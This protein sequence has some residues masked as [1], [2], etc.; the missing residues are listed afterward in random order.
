MGAPPSAASRSVSSGKP[1]PP[2]DRVS[3]P[4]PCLA[5]GSAP[6]NVPA[7]SPRTRTRSRDAWAAPAAS[8]IQPM[9]LHPVTMARR[10]WRSR[11][12]SEGLA[13]ARSPRASLATGSVPPRP[14]QPDNH[15]PEHGGE[16]MLAAATSHTGNRRWPGQNPVQRVQAA[17]ECGVVGQAR[18]QA[19]QQGRLHHQHPDRT[20]ASTPGRAITART[21]ID[22]RD[23]GQGEAEA[24]IVERGALPAPVSRCQLHAGGAK[25]R[26]GWKRRR[27]HRQRVMMVSSSAVDRVSGIQTANH[28][29]THRLRVL[30][31]GSV[32]RTRWTGDAWCRC[33]LATLGRC[34][35]PCQIMSAARAGCGKPPGRVAAG[36]HGRFRR[37]FSAW[38]PCGPPMHYM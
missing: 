22:D 10:A 36:R 13:G 18:Q 28:G 7:R 14:S 32:S 33:M 15:G 24:V 26:R 34:G 16:F 35:R 30:R 27:M 23:P 1:V 17:V 11:H 5:A 25:D 2:G 31:T 37:P 29:E 6:G 12:R 3:S 21:K 9:R 8:M 19:L 20:T 4:V 38:N